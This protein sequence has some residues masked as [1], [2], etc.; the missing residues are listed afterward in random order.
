MPE[1][2]PRGGA[3]PDLEALSAF[4]DGMAT[5]RERGD[6]ETHLASC[7]DC[8]ELVSEMI[9]VQVPI[10]T[11]LRTPT[12]AST[13]SETPFF[14]RKA[15]LFG[16]AALA[17]AAA[18]V[19]A[20][21]MQPRPTKG[22]ESGVALLVAAVG[23]DRP[24]EARL[25]GE[26]PAVPYRGAERST[27]A[28]PNYALLAAAGELQQTAEREPTAENLH[29]LGVAQL[30]LGE[31]E[32]AVATLDTAVAESPDD[33]SALSDA[34]AALLARGDAFDRAQD[35]PRAL[36]AAE[37]ALGRDRSHAPALFNKALALE[38]MNVRDAAIAA[39]DDY[40]QI[41]GGSNWSREARDRRARIEARPQSQ[42]APPGIH[43]SNLERL[44]AMVKE[45]PAR[46]RSWLERDVLGQW[47]TFPALQPLPEAA[48]PAAQALFEVTRD[49][50]PVTLV[51]SALSACANPSACGRFRAAHQ[52]YLASVAAL[53]ANLFDH[54]APLLNAAVPQLRASGNPLEAHAVLGL[55]RVAYNRGRV[56]E[57]VRIANRVDA[58]G[59]PFL[60]GELHR[61]LGVCA[62]SRGLLDETRARYEAMRRAFELTGDA[63]SIA[64]ATN[65]LAT[66]K[67]YVGD[68]A[69]SWGDRLDASRLM[70]STTPPLLRH[71][72][73]TGMVAAA[74]AQ[75]LHHA[76]AVLQEAVVA[77]AEAA[78][79]GALVEALAQLAVADSRVGASQNVEQ[80]LAA[81]HQ[82]LERVSDSGLR[83]RI[84]VQVL[85]AQAQSLAVTAPD[86]AAEAARTAIAQ[87]S[88]RGDRLRLAQLHVYLAAAE[89]RR[90]DRAAA[91]AAVERGISV[92][93]EERSLLQEEQRITYFDASWELFQ[94]KLEPLFAAGDLD[95][96]FR[97]I[98]AS[99]ARTLRESRPA[100]GSTSASAFQR[101]LA[102]DEAV[103]ILSQF[104]HRLGLFVL[105]RDDRGFVW[106][107]VSA[108]DAERLV[109]LSR[110]PASAAQAEQ[111]LYDALIRPVAD[112][113][114]GVSTLRV[115]PDA[116]FHH[117]PFPALRDAESN[118]FL[119]ED[120][121]VIVSPGLEWQSRAPRDNERVLVVSVPQP[122]A[123]FAPLPAVRREAESIAQLY[124]R[125]EW[126]HQEVATPERV[127]DAF[128]RANV[129]HVAAHARANTEFPFL[130]HLALSGS[131]DNPGGLLFAGALRS[132]DLSGVR[133]VV[134]AACD[135][136]EGP[137]RRGEGV[138]SLARGV[139]AAGAATVVA[140][141]APVADQESEQLFVEFHRRLAAGLTV[142]EAMRQA[143]LVA[144]RSGSTGSGW[145]WTVVAGSGD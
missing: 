14:R 47:A 8:F 120:M 78:H 114:R 90:G 98:D 64:S 84:L 87:V 49:P 41:D 135:T 92:F 11:N 115:V 81:A 136:A 7:E 16:I 50:D 83:A 55:A 13:L 59:R 113:L 31:Y 17:T 79:P 10:Q 23:A 124:P 53:D 138:L 5:E 39:W 9:A 58:S 82:A 97:V 65:M 109:R 121:A 127:L 42:W 102:A 54:A 123:P 128:G 105:R 57:A 94:R 74:Q 99:R 133:V 43:E 69:E 131:E 119:I 103:L 100:S 25:S 51:R 110:H 1:W 38:K 21:W 66:F 68:F 106:S 6:I 88:A 96:A 125:A 122:A 44:R 15:P 142:A 108:S 117:A 93:E 144:V 36:D 137:L 139:L 20:V 40:L 3:H 60:E 77:N 111:S 2:S 56:D 130:S 101:N 30:L 35:Y 37:R 126:L 24:I 86:R 29:A 85:T 143:Q 12:A 75:G 46:M 73:L 80:H 140:T 116:P 104:E 27:Q 45:E 62:F 95:A 132:R 89:M 52:A 76:A 32:A 72:L 134:L 141:L 33:V 61:L 4:V 22:T 34:A 67:R 91:A 26:F 145:R 19:L 129:I 63:Q 71:S 70:R 48:Q 18:V 112:A 28:T 107:S 118:R